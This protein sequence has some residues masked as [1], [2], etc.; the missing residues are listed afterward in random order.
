MLCFQLC[1]SKETCQ[2]FLYVMLNAEYFSPI[3]L[4]FLLRLA[5]SILC[6]LVSLDYVRRVAGLLVAGREV[7]MIRSAFIDLE[8]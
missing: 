5:R 2:H 7:D 3:G 8:E 6:Y 4:S 1:F